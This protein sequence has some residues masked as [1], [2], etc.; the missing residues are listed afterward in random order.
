MFT[1]RSFENTI[2]NAPLV[3]QNHS[4]W[5]ILLSCCV[6]SVCN[7]SKWS[8]IIVGRRMVKFGV[9]IFRIA[10]CAFSSAFRFISA[11]FSF[12][13]SCLSHCLFSSL[14]LSVS[15]FLLSQLLS[16][17]SLLHSISSFL[18]AQIL[19]I[20]PHVSTELLFYL[21]M[22]SLVSFSEH[23]VFVMISILIPFRRGPVE[24][25]GDRFDWQ[26][27]VMVVPISLFFLLLGNHLL[28]K[29]CLP[30][31][32]SVILCRFFLWYTLR[33]LK[34]AECLI[35]IIMT[36]KKSSLFSSICPPSGTKFRRTIC[37]KFNACW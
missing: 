5:C 26:Q 13:F 28:K 20:H 17:L 34:S 4:Q 15:F 8:R 6:V 7:V 22:S 16:F 9:L 10:S 19:L 1:W 3:C 27:R 2:L 30:H 24:F 12:C 32:Y 14:S 33:V 11:S 25:W 35:F 36:P 31:L 29:N 18:L 37:C 21:L 23:C